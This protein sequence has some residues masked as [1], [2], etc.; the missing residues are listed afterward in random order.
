MHLERRGDGE[1]RSVK[2]KPFGLEWGKNM[3]EITVIIDF[4]ETTENEGL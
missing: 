1:G 3:G 2:R 4:P